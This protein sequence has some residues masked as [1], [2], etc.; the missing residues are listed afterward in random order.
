[1]MKKEIA[2]GRVI[3]MK[4]THN[5]LTCLFGYHVYSGELTNDNH[6]NL[7]YLC[8]ICKRRGY[9]DCYNGR[10]V[11]FDYDKEGVL[12]CE[13]WDSGVQFWFG[14]HGPKARKNDS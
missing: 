3:G 11:W 12:I 5:K 8:K 10:K 6:G 7:I 14:N 9:K 4:K 2:Y 13:T 1:M